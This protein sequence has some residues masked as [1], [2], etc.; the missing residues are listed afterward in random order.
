LLE[1]IPES[2]FTTDRLQHYFSHLIAQHGYTVG[3][4][5]HPLRVAV[6]GLKDSPGPYDTIAVLKKK[7]A[8]RRIKMALKKLENL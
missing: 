7:E 6:T 5:L 8:V 4:V 1:T 2:Q 3:E